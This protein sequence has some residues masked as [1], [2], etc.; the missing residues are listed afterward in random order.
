MEKNEITMSQWRMMIWTPI[1]I[2]AIVYSIFN[3]T[4]FI[5]KESYQWSLIASIGGMLIGWGFG[6]A[7]SKKWSVEGIGK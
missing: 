5:P 6:L 1:A 4:L 3:S 2:G 7:A